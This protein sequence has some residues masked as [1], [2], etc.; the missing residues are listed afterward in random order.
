MKKLIT[1]GLI[2][3]ASFSFGQSLSPTVINAA[4]A[5]YQGSTANL[6]VSIGEPVIDTYVYTG[7]VLT[8]GFLQGDNAT[9]TLNLT[10][11]IEGLYNGIGQNKAKDE[12]GNHF[13]GNIAD[14]LVVS[15]ARNTSPYDILF[16]NDTVN[17]MTNGTAAFVFP[18][19]YS[20]NNYVV[21][22]HR[23]SIET[24]TANPL[25]LANMTSAYSFID[26]AAKAYGSNQASFGNVYAFYSGDVNQD[27]G[28]DTGDMSP[29][30]NDG[31][32]FVS[33]YVA[34]DVNGDGTVDTGDMTIIDNNGMN[35]VSSVTPL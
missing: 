1:F 34:T 21:I 3:T 11:Y 26:A 18:S 32:N 7:S 20:G 12:N 10:L 8:T 35:F 14:K 17:L 29:A 13:P 22:H 6:T 15:L 5:S 33:G 16:T 19:R 31:A 25:S 24:W 23:N 27:G 2:L 30:D 28:I 9:H 4:G